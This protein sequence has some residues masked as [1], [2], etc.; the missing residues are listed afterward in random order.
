MNNNSVRMSDYITFAELMGVKTSEVNIF[1]P[2]NET[3]PTP[4]ASLDIQTLCGIAPGANA[5]VWSMPNSSFLMEWAYQVSNHT[6]PPQVFSFSYGI[7]EAQL[8]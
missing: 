1:G 4:E 3:N 7:M 5:T 2:N 8:K 6:N